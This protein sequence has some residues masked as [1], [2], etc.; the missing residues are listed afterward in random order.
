[1]NAREN[2]IRALE[3]RA[4]EW[5]PAVVDL[6]E[7][8]WLRH[9]R[10]LAEVVLAHPTVFPD[11]RAGSVPPA[12]S[13]DP[14]CEAY[15]A[16]RDDWGCTWR[17]TTR[18]ILGQVVGH[19][20]SDWS[21]LA[22][23]T[24]PNPEEQFDWSAIADRIQAER[25][26][27]RLAIGY[28]SITQSGIFDRLQFL[29]GLENLLVDF[30]T[31]PPELDRLLEM[32]VEHSVACTRRC[33]GF[34][35]DIMYFHG[36]IGG[37]NGLLFSPEAFRRYL[38]PAY[39]EVFGL[40]RSAGTHVFYSSDGYVLDVVEDLVECGASLHDPEVSTN[41]LPGIRAAYAGKLCASIQLDAQ[42]MPSARPEELREH[43]R[44]TVRGMEDPRGGLMVY[45]Y[46]GADVPLAN[47]DALCDE[48]ESACGMP[49]A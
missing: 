46:V 15:E 5:V 42:R 6:A 25:R 48:M 12:A 3:F 7:S 20:L 14:F 26:A 21:A 19:P 38:K 23:F 24:P 33:L 16:K 41:T 49:A 28:D 47:V 9:G 31:S 8:A 17:N 36:D 1:M 22:R 10:S 37:Q 29:R 32:V 30:A 43:V 11:F 27:G 4:P 13:S 34:G 44:Q 39:R 40:C 18:G 35:V 45:A 2:Y